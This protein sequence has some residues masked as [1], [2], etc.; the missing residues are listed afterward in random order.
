M[1]F[2]YRVDLVILH[3]TILVLAGTLEVCYLGKVSHVNFI[4]VLTE[5][6]QAAIEQLALLGAVEKKED[7]LILTPLGKKMAAFPLEPKFSKV[8][9]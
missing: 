9:C 7:Q 8:T 2:L 5:A 4:F 1:V 6:L 3:N